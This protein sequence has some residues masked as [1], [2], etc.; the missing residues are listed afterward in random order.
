MFTELNNIILDL[1]KQLDEANRELH[2]TKVEK[3]N[4]YTQVEELKASHEVNAN[5]QAGILTVNLTAKEAEI[6]E[7]KEKLYQYKN[8]AFEGVERL[9]T[10]QS[11]NAKL[12]EALE[13][14]DIELSKCKSL[15]PAKVKNRCENAAKYQW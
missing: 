6:K 7:L 9:S 13:E 5:T 4:L 14:R 3:N 12:V 1:Q 11:Q 10:L 15:T 8:L 2:D